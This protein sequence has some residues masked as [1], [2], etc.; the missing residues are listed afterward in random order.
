LQ[1]ENLSPDM[2][3]EWGLDELKCAPGL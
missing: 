2:F 1:I 3:L